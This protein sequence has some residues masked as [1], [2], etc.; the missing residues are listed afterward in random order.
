MKLTTRLTTS[1]RARVKRD[2]RWQPVTVLNCIQLDGGTVR[3]LVRFADGT[4][5]TLDRALLRF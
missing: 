2:N 5:Q 4:E 1:V 3:H